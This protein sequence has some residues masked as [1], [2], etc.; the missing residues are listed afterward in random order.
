MEKKIFLYVR[1]VEKR[2]INKGDR[3]VHETKKGQIKYKE[4]ETT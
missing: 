3:I 2:D 1:L 4:N